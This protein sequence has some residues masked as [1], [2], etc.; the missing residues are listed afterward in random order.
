MTTDVSDAIR[1]NIDS[2][3]NTLTKEE[4]SSSGLCVYNA[5][6]VTYGCT[7]RSWSAIMMIVRN[8]LENVDIGK[9]KAL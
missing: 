6:S 8:T 4:C 9:S 7:D 2:T 5:K 1:K 3:S